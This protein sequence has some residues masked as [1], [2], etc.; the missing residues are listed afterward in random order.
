MPSSTG[1]KC[2]NIDLVLTVRSWQ[3]VAPEWSSRENRENVWPGL[4]SLHWVESIVTLQSHSKREIKQIQASGEL[5]LKI[6]FMSNNKHDKIPPILLSA[7]QKLVFSLGEYTN[8]SSSHRKCRWQSLSHFAPE[9]WA[10]DTSTIHSPHNPSCPC[11]STRLDR[12]STM[13]LNLIV[14]N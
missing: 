7:S 14:K 12:E 11:I 3:D 13:Y 1:R 6:S 10:S 4:S 5:L 8:T 9:V 2:L